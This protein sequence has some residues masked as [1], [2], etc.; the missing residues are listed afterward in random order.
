VTLEAWLNV[1]I[2]AIVPGLM[3]AV[4]L[5]LAVKATD[6]KGRHWY[7]AAFGILFLSSIGIAVWLQILATDRQVIADRKAN[8]TEVKH[9]GD[10]EYLKGELNLLTTILSNQKP[11]IS[12]A[13][14]QPAADKP[15]PS[16]QAS[17]K[18]AIRE[19]LADFLQQGQVLMDRCLREA[20]A[21]TEDANN[22]ATNVHSYLLA[23]LDKSYDMR[24]LNPPPALPIGHGVAEEND[25]LWRALSVRM[26]VLRAFISDL[27]D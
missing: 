19:K 10:M 13:G 7:E 27:R 2:I 20:K 26:D 24:F 21:P 1:G 9:I 14:R 6:L 5:R 22:W 23:N 8:D 17:S 16:V 25:H 12:Q 3:A 11:G 15:K 18:A 4:G